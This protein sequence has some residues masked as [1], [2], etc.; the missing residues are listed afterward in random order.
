MKQF[1]KRVDKLRGKCLITVDDSQFNRD[2]FSDC[3]VEHVTTRN[4][5]TNNRTHAEATFG[6]LLI[7]P[8]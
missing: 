2:L 1:R 6:E 4:R 7:E 3:K 5:L 8:K